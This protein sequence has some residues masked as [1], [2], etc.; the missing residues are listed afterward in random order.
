MWYFCIHVYARRRQFQDSL[1]GRKLT[2]LPVYAI[3]EPIYNSVVDNSNTEAVLSRRSVDMDGET[4]FGNVH[5]DNLICQSGK[6]RLEI[7][8]CLWIVA[9]YSW[10]LCSIFRRRF[11]NMAGEAYYDLITGSPVG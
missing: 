5:S 6:K 1:A 8:N 2:P 3:P 10:F 9:V 4:A 7:G 11:N